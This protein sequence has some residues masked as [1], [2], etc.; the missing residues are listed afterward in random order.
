VH[1][2]FGLNREIKIMNE[3]ITKFKRL[4]KRISQIDELVRRVDDIQKAIG[5]IETRQLIPNIKSL[6]SVHDYEFK[7][8]SQWGVDGIIQ[9]L[10]NNIEIKNRVFIEFGVQDYKESNTRFLLQHNN[11]SGLIIDASK[12]NIEKIKQDE[13]YFRNDL[14]AVCSFIDRDNINTIISD[15]SIGGDI[16]LLS[17]DIDGNDYWIWEAINYISPRIVIC[18]YDNLLGCQRA[19]TTPY[20][21]NFERAKAHYSYLYGGASITALYQLGLKK[22]YSL[23]GSNSA[24]NNA[25]FVR[26]DVL[27]NLPTMS[28]QQAYITAK[29]RNSR[30]MAG[31]QTY[32]NFDDSRRLIAEMPLFDLNE[33]KIIQIHDIL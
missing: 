18:E 12:E 19:V 26:N 28:P 16:G 3:L 23:V 20:D 22:G 13:I 6:K 24:G 2:V 9:F 27:G 21:K 1:L 25:F 31:N 32:L 7:V 17:I 8:Y 11:W 14:R 5:R 29:F 10:I 33:N 30:D 4:K 15:S